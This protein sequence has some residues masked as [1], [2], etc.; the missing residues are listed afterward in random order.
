MIKTVPCFMC[1]NRHIEFGCGL[2]YTPDE[3][4]D[5]EAFE[6]EENEQTSEVNRT[7]KESVNK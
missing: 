6:Q 3:N 4:N 2:H 5:C 7:P 1:A